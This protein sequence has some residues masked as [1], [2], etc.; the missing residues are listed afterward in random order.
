MHHPVDHVSSG[1]CTQW[2]T[3]PVDHRFPVDHYVEMVP[4]GPLRGTGAQWTTTLYWFP[5]DHYLEV[6]TS[7]PLFGSGYP[8]DHYVVHIGFH[9]IYSGLMLQRYIISPLYIIIRALSPSLVA[10]ITLGYVLKLF[11]M[12]YYIFVILMILLFII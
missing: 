12:I 2:T 9:L 7:E 5:V 11:I 3:S 10:V 6:V 4:S 1:P 8:V